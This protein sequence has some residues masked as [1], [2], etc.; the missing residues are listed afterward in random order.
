MKAIQV[1]LDEPLLAR[2]DTSREVREGGRSAVIRRA[3]RE[4]LNR[5]QAERVSEAYARAYGG[6]TRPGDE[7]SGWEDEGVWPES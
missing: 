4:Y 6:D 2:L 3:T 7:L 5:R 1:M